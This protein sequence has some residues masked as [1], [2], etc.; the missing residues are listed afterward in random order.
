MKGVNLG[1]WLVLEKWMDPEMFAGSE[2]E[3][4]TYFCKGLPEEEKQRRYKKHRDSYITEQDFQYIAEAGFDTVRIPVPYFLFEDF[5]PFI[6]CYEYLDRAF[7]WA[8]KYGLKILVD[9]HTVPGGQNGTDNS[10]LCGICTWSTK[11]EYLDIMLDVWEKIAE[12]YGKKE[13]LWGVEALNE[14]MCSDTPLSEY[15]NIQMLGKVYHPEDPEMAKDNTNYPLS[16][17][18][19][20]YRSAYDRMRKYLPAEKV[21]VF[22]DAF[23]LEGWEEFFKEKQFENI[24]LDT[25]QYLTMVEYGFGEDRPIEKYENYLEG[26]EKLLTDTAAKVP[27][28]VG[29]WSLGNSMTGYEKAGED[30][31]AEALHRLYMVYRKA[32]DVCDGWFYWNY[33]LLASEPEK[34]VWDMRTCLENKWITID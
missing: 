31:K 3:D 20:F 4:E 19:D 21:I 13:V 10:G 33:K 32:V 7:E 9:L 6:H 14:P 24:V 5:E 27:T 16:Y 29:E 17:L 23:Y 34:Q 30:E 1:N 12:R 11:K 22:S 15:M 18:R 2:A 8:E 28:I 26:L 25:H